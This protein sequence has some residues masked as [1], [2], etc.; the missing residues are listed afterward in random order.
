M[1]GV[2]EP[3]FSM[4]NLSTFFVYQGQFSIRCIKSWRSPV[5]LIKK[6]AFLYHHFGVEPWYDYKV[7]LIAT[8]PHIPSFSPPAMRR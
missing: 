1:A 6:K 4:W 7:A 3:K 8:I 5:F 2:R